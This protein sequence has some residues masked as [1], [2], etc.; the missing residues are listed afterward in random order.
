MRRLPDRDIDHMPYAPW[1]ELHAWP[2]QTENE[3]LVVKI[4]GYKS[5]AYADTFF[6]YGLND[7]ADCSDEEVDDG[8]WEDD[9][10]SD[11]AEEEVEG[12]DVEK[13]WQLRCILDCYDMGGRCVEVSETDSGDMQIC[14]MPPLELSHTISR[15]LPFVYTFELPEEGDKLPRLHVCPSGVT[16]AGS[17]YPGE[18]E[19]VQ[20]YLRLNMSGTLNMYSV[21]MDTDATADSVSLETSSF[22]HGGFGEIGVEHID[23][24][25]VVDK[26]FDSAIFLSLRKE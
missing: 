18:P 16:L 1:G 19:S 7:D 4:T 10:E 15:L 5:G 6:V 24:V 13:A 26:P 11:D 21:S 9:G 23:D 8:E 3:L 25:F 20:V 14:A 12:S 2:V 17:L 22:S